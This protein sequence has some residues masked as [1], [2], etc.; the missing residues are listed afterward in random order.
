MF[1]DMQKVIHLESSGDV[2]LPH[3]QHVFNKS[4]TGSPP[5]PIITTKIHCTP[6][7]SFQQCLQMLLNAVLTKATSALKAMD[8]S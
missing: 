6:P 7:N 8:F 5:L 2:N 4:I 1:A 3:Q